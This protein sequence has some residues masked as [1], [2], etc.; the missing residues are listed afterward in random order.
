MNNAKIYSSHEIIKHRMGELLLTLISRANDAA[1]SAQND[2]ENPGPNTFLF[3]TPQEIEAR[4]QKFNRIGSYLIE[5]HKR[6][7]SQVEK[8]IQPYAK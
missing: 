4:R 2:L 1:D 6:L 3:Q 8:Q 7:K 5:R